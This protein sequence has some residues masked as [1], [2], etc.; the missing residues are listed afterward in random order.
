MRFTSF[1]LATI[2]ALAA[3]P[4]VAQETRIGYVNIGRLMDQ[5]PQ[6]EVANKALEREFSQRG[7]ALVVERDALKQIQDRLEKEGEIM[8]AEKRAE[9]ER[10]F[11]NRSRDFRRAQELFNED[12]NLRRNEEIGKLQKQIHLIIVEI[13]KREQIDLV[14]ADNVLFASDRIDI[15]SKV[16][17]RLRQIQ[18]GKGN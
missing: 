15:T 4:A 13:A 1:V 5:A 11:R 14:V 3:A 8:S 10:D 7:N 9:L 18:S 16:L 2:I 17:D 12:L 6:A